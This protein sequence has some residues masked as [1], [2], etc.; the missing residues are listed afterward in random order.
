MFHEG[1]DFVF[2]LNQIKETLSLLQPKKCFSFNY[3]Y[4][5]YFTIGTI[6]QLIKIWKNFMTLITPE[7]LISLKVHSCHVLTMISAKISHSVAKVEEKAS[8]WKTTVL[9]P[10]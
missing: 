8:Y 2:L 9:S 6:T 7:L 4:L 1:P 3:K 10:V 5:G